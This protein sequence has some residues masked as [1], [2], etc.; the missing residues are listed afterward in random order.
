MTWRWHDLGYWIH[1]LSHLSNVLILLDDHD[2]LVTSFTCSKI[3]YDK[4]VGDKTF[5]DKNWSLIIAGDSILGER[6]KPPSA[7]GD[8][9]VGDRI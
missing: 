8:N 1:N 4:N 9:I 7:W 6:K 5:K 3:S 2:A